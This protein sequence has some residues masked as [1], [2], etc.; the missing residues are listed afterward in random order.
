MQWNNRVYEESENVPGNAKWLEFLYGTNKANSKPKESV[1]D[2]QP[3]NYII[4]YPTVQLPPHPNTNLSDLPKQSTAHMEVYDTEDLMEF[5]REKMI[6]RQP[7]Q[8]EDPFYL[9][10]TSN[11]DSFK[12]Y[13]RP[14][15]DSINNSSAVNAMRDKMG[16]FLDESVFATP[17]DENILRPDGMLTEN[18]LPSNRSGMRSIKDFIDHKTLKYDKFHDALTDEELEE[19][20]SSAEDSDNTPTVVPT[21]SKFVVPF[22][23]KDKS[24]TPLHKPKEEEQS[25]SKSYDR[26]LQSLV[27]PNATSESLEEK[28]G[29]SL[30]YEVISK[31]EAD[32]PPSSN[33]DKIDS[34]MMPIL[35]WK[36]KEATENSYSENIKDSIEIQVESDEC[37]T[38]ENKES[39]TNEKAGS[40]PV[41]H[42]S[43][44]IENINIEKSVSADLEA[45]T[46]EKV[47]DSVDI[48]ENSTYLLSGNNTQCSTDEPMAESVETR[49][50]E[51][52]DN[53]ED[54]E[55]NIIECNIELEGINESV[56]EIRLY[57]G[58]GSVDVNKIF[59][60]PETTQLETGLVRGETNEPPI[61]VPDEINT[62]KSVEIVNVETETNKSDLRENS[63]MEVDTV[64][65]EMATCES[66]EE[67]KLTDI[68]NSI[69]QST[70]QDECIQASEQNTEIRAVS[71]NN[72]IECTETLTDC[73]IEE[74]SKAAL[75]GTEYSMIDTGVQ[76]SQQSQGITVEDKSI[77]CALVTESKEC[78]TSLRVIDGESQ[79]CSFVTEKECQTY[80]FVTDRDCQTISF[81][82]DGDC[83]TISF[84]TDRDCQTYIE[85]PE[86]IEESRELI[87]QEIQTGEE[88]GSKIEILTSREIQTEEITRN[89]S[90]NQTDILLIRFPIECNDCE[91]KYEQYEYEN[92]ILYQ[93]QIIKAL[94][95]EIEWS[96]L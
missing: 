61:E 30:K 87:S 2:N 39:I 10:L 20:D 70:Y 52:N 49:L 38:Q 78:Q 57:N 7:G 66:Q 15:I 91:D 53:S 92:F 90:G 3:T 72:E 51:Q 4:K 89:N 47:V 41:E 36:E 64:P 55:M 75:E 80:S 17:A 81:V 94:Q 74:A 58:L 88:I 24:P 63:Q 13:K 85:Y 14:R 48:D 37:D 19:I 26:F 12:G 33:N 65:E 60:S 84:V 18:P 62:I 59:A 76:Y 83:Q 50:E 71:T 21:K 82:T 67:N 69:N 16:G 31:G 27:A 29:S 86:P 40:N 68:S 35:K 6:R 77:D 44:V 5:E 79:T 11:R 95:K 45:D 93:Q 1:S 42:Q 46:N 96:N 54:P 22:T 28:C 32:I 43:V 9:T 8:S 56:D 23:S 73:N 25:S 34:L